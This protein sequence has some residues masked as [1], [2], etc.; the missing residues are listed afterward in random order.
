V[1]AIRKLLYNDEIPA[2]FNEFMSAF[3]G[4]LPE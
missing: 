2:V 1:K 3:A 4:M